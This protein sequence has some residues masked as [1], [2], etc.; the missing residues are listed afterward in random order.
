M[1]TAGCG[2]SALGGK[3]AGNQPKNVLARSVYLRAL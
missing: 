3:K 1:P 2:E